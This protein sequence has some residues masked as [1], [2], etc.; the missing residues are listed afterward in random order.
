[1]K[2]Y[3]FYE[4]DSFYYLVSELCTGYELYDK[5]NIIGSFREHD[6]AFIIS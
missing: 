1:L 3:E 5:L 4:D 6:A 2:I